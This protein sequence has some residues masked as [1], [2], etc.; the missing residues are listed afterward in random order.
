MNQLG[1]KDPLVFAVLPADDPSVTREYWQ[2]IA[3]YLAEGIG[4]EVELYLVPDYSAQIEALR[5][6]HVDLARASSTSYVAALR[7]GVEIEPIA[8][9]IKGN[10]GL[11]GYYGYIVVQE[12][13]DVEDMAD[14]QERSFAFVD[15]LSASGHIVPACALELAGVT[16]GEVFMAGSHDA[17]ILAVQNGTVE[18]GAVVQ[19]RL[20]AAVDRGVIADGELRV[21]WRSD[22]IP[23]V[24]IVVQ[25]SMDAELKMLLQKLFIDMPSELVLGT[26]RTGEVGYVKAVDADYDV[27]REIEAF[28]NK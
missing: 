13:S 21:I 2:P 19:N 9:S 23:T 26:T 12:G 22:L 11:P 7:D 16:V 14:L 4:Y 28:V 5:A 10:T 8:M 15:V 20:E 25:S 18:A 6:G 24:P 17:V 27:V 3:D 1:S